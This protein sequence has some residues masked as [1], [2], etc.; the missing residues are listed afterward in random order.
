VESPK[1]TVPVCPQ[2]GKPTKRD[3]CRNCNAAYMRHYQRQ[4]RRT[5][6]GRAMWERAQK[7]A[8]ERNLEFSLHKDSVFVPRNC[9]VLGVAITPGSK[10]AATSPSLD[11]ILPMRGYVPDNVRVIC[12]HAN[13]LKGDRSLDELKGLAEGGPPEFRADYRMI[14]TYLEREMLLR[15]VREKAMQEGRAGEEW[16]KIALFLDR[17][18]RRPL[19][20][21]GISQA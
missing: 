7:R 17:L 19:I 8:F 1:N 21:N 10:R 11:R 18:F 5:M 6:P 12:D 4:R 2:H 13:R 15:E 9:P 20:R 14:V 16:K 3:T